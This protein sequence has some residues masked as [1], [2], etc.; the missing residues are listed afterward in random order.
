[1]GKKDIRLNLIIETLKAKP[2]ISIKELADKYMVSEMTIRRDLHQIS[3]SGMMNASKPLYDIKSDYMFS[4]EQIKHYEQKERIAQFAVSLISPEDVLIIDSGTT[5]S[6]LSKL[7]PEDISVTALCYNFQVLNQLHTKPNVSIIFAGGYYHPN[8]QMFESAEGVSLIQRIRATKMFVSASGV[9]KELGITC[10]N[11]YEVVTKRAA[12]N[13]SYLKILL[14]DS[15]KFGAIRQGYF[16]Q[17]KDIDVI[18]TDDALS[19]DWSQFIT[20]HGIKLHLV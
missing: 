19:S 7:L 17:L 10:A 13:S 14:A 6:V 5:T 20:E 15:S 11:N 4:N 8:D 9:H 1:M 18:V 12:L 16:A 2:N 3:S